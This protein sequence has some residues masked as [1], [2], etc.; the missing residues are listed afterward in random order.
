MKKKLKRSTSDRVLGGLAGGIAEYFGV[1]STMVRLAII[2]L[3]VFSGIGPM[4]LIYFIAW[5]IIPKDKDEVAEIEHLKK[6]GRAAKFFGIVFVIFG[7]LILLDRI[8]PGFYVNMH[9]Y[10][11]S[12]G[13]LVPVALILVGI[14]IL[15]RHDKKEEDS[16]ESKED[17][18]DKKAE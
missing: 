4:V 13:I 7:G 9:H 18:S 12:A 2:I 16:H 15:S 6:K 11:E 5:L 14:W 3:A 1:D 10:R 17:H 8:A